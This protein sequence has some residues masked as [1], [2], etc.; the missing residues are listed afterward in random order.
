MDEA[1]I[2]LQVISHSMPSAEEIP[3]GIAPDLVKRVN[4]RLAESCSRH[5]FRFAAFATLPTAVPDRAAD[6]LERCVR[7]LGFKGALVHPLTHGV[8]FDDQR[9]WPIF[10]TA[11]KLGVPIYLHPGLPHADVTNIYYRDYAKRYPAIVGAALGFGIETAALA[12]RLILSGVFKKHSKLT[13]ILGHMGEAL[14]FIL[15]RTHMALSRPGHDAIDFREEFRRHFWV[16]TSGNFSTPA[17]LCAMLEL[18]IDRIMFSIDYPFV[19]NQVGMNWLQTLQ[20]SSD[21]T[22]KLLS[23]NATRLLKL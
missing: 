9:F 8:F 22:L 18:G 16:T 1:G 12:M 10:E 5:P 4:D 3:A 7:D 20:I 19:G 21:D 11:E 17:L 14:P 23:G 13:F 2:D 15:W 6:E